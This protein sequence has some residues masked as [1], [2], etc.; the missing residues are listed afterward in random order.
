MKR[1]RGLSLRVFVPLASATLLA[2]VIIGTSQITERHMR[3][4]LSN[5]IQTRLLLEARNLAFLGSLALL[6]DF[7][8]LTLVPLVTDMMKDRPDLALAVVID[9]DGTVQGHKDPRQLGSGYVLSRHLV[10]QTDRPELQ[11]GETFW[12]DADLLVVEVP[13]NHGSEHRLGRVFLGM[14]KAYETALIGRARHA[15]TRLTAIVLPVFTILTAIMI[16]LFLRPIGTLRKGLERIGRGDLDS[17]MVVSDRT[18]LGRLADVVNEM[19]GQLKTS[20]ALAQARES[21][22]IETQKEIIHTLG[23][24]V[25]TRS[26]E[27]ANHTRRV[28][29]MS[30]RLALLAGLP[31]QEANLLRLAAPMHDVGKIGIPDRILNKPGSLTRKELEIMRSHTTI[32]YRILTKSERP[33][34]KSAAIIANEHHERWDGRGY[35]RG[36]VGEQTHLYG[37]IVAVADVFDALYS[38]RVYRK[39]M[40]LDEVLDIINV[41]RGHHLDPRLA[42]LMLSHVDAFTAISEEYCE[43]TDTS[44][45]T[46]HSTP[47]VLSPAPAPPTPARQRDPYREPVGSKS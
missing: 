4:A 19:A 20:R 14:H 7:P 42:D 39:A 23:E 1:R 6:N 44:I 17:P 8:E 38:D 35:P 32:G 5:E 41:E 33:V 45:T 46:D 21:E 25:E 37:R 10:P 18:E 9:H 43:I 2:V 22:V 12:E 29:E 27:T 34:L 16:S 47:P 36:L 24:V 31:E 15:L 30:H 40:P 13:I 3:T 28:G 11:P 26:L